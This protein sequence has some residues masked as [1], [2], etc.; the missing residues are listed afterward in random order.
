[1]RLLLGI[2]SGVLAFL[3][4]DTPVDSS[5]QHMRLPE[6]HIVAYTAPLP[7]PQAYSIFK[8]KLLLAKS[9]EGLAEKTLAVARSFEGTPYVGGTLESNGT[10]KLVVNLTEVDCWTFM[11]NSLAL[12]LSAQTATSHFDS[13]RHHLQELRYYGGQINGYASRIHYFSAWL[14]QAEK[15]GYLTDITQSL[16]GIPYNKPVNFMSTHPQRYPKLADQGTLQ[17]IRKAEKALSTEKKFYIPQNQIEQIEDKLQDGDIIALTSWK[18]GLDIAHQGFAVRKN[19]R[20]HLLHASSLGKRVLISSLPLSRYI[21]TQKGQTG[22]MVARLR[23][24]N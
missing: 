7:D 15:T 24:T 9:R 21:R 20:V 5:E 18:R 11:E 3:S 14:D 22:I 17:K 10:E 6:N 13:F 19:G 12:A 23:T 1:M 8:Q 4:P 16:G 2:L